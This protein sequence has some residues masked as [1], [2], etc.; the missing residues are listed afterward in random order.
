L[1]PIFELL[2][3]SWQIVRSL[4]PPARAGVVQ[5]RCGGGTA[6]KRRAR[7]LAVCV[8]WSGFRQNG[9]ALSRL[10]VELVD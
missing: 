2:G 6:A 1:H 8:A 9:V 10:V 5:C 3:N 4:A 7:F